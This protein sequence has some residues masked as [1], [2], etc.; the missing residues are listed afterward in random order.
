MSSDAWT[1]LS[2]HLDCMHAVQTSVIFQALM[3]P[4]DLSEE[5]FKAKESPFDKQLHYQSRPLA[6]KQHKAF[7]S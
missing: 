6:M 1:G 2:N 5:P 4:T 7:G 3:V